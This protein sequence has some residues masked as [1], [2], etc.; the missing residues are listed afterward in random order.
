MNK[1]IKI[2][3]SNTEQSMQEGQL[4]TK[5]RRMQAIYGQISLLLCL[6]IEFTRYLSI[7]K[8]DYVKCSMAGSRLIVEK[9]DF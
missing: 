3:N 9:A 5:I 8:G 4:D 6:P 7:S 1:P 2:Q